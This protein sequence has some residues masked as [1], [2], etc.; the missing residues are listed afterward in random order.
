MRPTN[1][2]L[3]LIALGVSLFSPL[4]SAF[5]LQS[6][7]SEQIE[8]QESTTL[9]NET[10]TLEG[11]SENVES[12][13]FSPFYSDD[14][15]LYVLTTTNTYVNYDYNNLFSLVTPENNGE[16]FKA[17]FSPNIDDNGVILLY[18]DQ[19]AFIS[20]ENGS[21]WDPISIEAPAPYKQV[22]V[23]PKF[24]TSQFYYVV[25]NEGLYR[26][27]TY[28]NSNELLMSSEP[29]SEVS[30]FLVAPGS[31]NDK[32][33]YAIKG[34]SLLKTESFGE[35]WMEH[36][37]GS[38]IKDIEIVNN[39]TNSGSIMVLTADNR[40][41][42]NDTQFEFYQIATPSEAN[43]IY[44]ISNVSGAEKE[45]VI[46]TDAGLF[47]SYDNGYLWNKIP[48]NLDNYNEI[49]D[50][51]ALAEPGRTILF[52]L[53]DGKLYKDEDTNGELE[54]FESGIETSNKFAL[55]GSAE[56]KNILDLVDESFP[57]NYYIDGATLVV[58]AINNEQSI[59]Y[60][61][62]V[63]DTNWEEVTP[64]QPHQFI[65]I[66]SILKWRIELSTD[67]ESTSAEINGIEVDFGFKGNPSEELCAGFSDINLMD[68]ICP[69]IKYV[70]TQGIFEGYPDGTFKANQEINRAETVKVIVEGF[71]KTILPMP[72]G[73]L[74]FSDVITGEWYM[75]YLSTAQSEGIIEGYP[76]GTFKPEQTVNYVEMI[77]VF[78]ETAGDALPKPE[79]G[80]EW[81]KAYLDYAMSNEYL[82]YSQLD[83][84][85]KRGDVAQLFYQ[86]SLK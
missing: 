32:L 13:F 6:P 5:L 37:F 34:M 45:Y 50:I 63:D 71:D 56:S 31:Q 57:D 69:A 70:Q 17:S 53:I 52:L 20:Y 26:Q 38:E 85:M 77:K 27:D 67:D 21:N 83:A 82:I 58:D 49:E 44:Y 74:G 24:S 84:G 4:C 39:S 1:L 23:G 46:A 80:S 25:N 2:K 86:R 28:G 79:S 22:S 29:E 76:D 65:N 8:T 60:Y 55:T 64:N 48:D 40:I 19:K 73:N 36:N 72:A 3:G 33:F 14:E 75:P 7:L 30:S 81:Y 59:R 47:I 12:L 51:H 18:N 15:I 78:F 68:P 41:F 54:L 61:M 42:R 43:E 9:T 11:S 66:G 62:T 16:A 35:S 10:L